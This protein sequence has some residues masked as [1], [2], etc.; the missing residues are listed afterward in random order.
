[1]PCLPYTSVIAVKSSSARSYPEVAFVPLEGRECQIAI[2]V[3]SDDRRPAIE[4]IRH[5]API[6][7]SATSRLEIGSGTEEIDS[8]R[9][10]QEIVSR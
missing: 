2:A 5:V 10:F 8:D 4:A 6:L 7:N 3:R 1:M 9:T